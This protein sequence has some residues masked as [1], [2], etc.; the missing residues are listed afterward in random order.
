MIP[1]WFDW[2][3]DTDGIRACYCFFP[4]S[5]F[6]PRRFIYCQHLREKKH[7]YLL[8]YSCDS[9]TSWKDILITVT[10]SRL[11]FKQRKRIKITTI[12]DFLNWKY[13]TLD[14]MLYLPL[15]G[16]KNTKH[17][18]ERLGFHSWLCRRQHDIK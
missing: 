12:V 16:S 14:K 6:L 10:V 13:Y 15:C 4:F 11:I 5:F 18:L 9:Y 2:L 7:Y 1:L 3:E 17:R 8:S